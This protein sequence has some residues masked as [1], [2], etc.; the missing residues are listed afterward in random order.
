MSIGVGDKLPEVNLF[1]Q[2]EKGPES[3][4]TSRIFAGKKVVLFALPGAYTY[5]CSSAH[6]PGYVVKAD[7][8]LERGVDLIAC[9]SVN[10]TWVMDAWGKQ[11]NAEKIMMIG[12]GNGD[13]TRQAGFEVDMSARGYGIRS[14]RYAMIVEDGVITLL[15]REAPGKFEVSDADSILVEL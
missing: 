5:V 1:I 7:E 3:L 8:L 4:P 11:Q 12:D 13:F 10:D 6:L 9:L 15:N 2:G 14:A